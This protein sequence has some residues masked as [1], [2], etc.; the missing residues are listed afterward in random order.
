MPKTI[1]KKFLFPDDLALA[2]RYE[3]DGISEQ[4]ANPALNADLKRLEPYY[5]WKRQRTNPDKKEVST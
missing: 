1:S 3:Y 5:L 4:F 2:D